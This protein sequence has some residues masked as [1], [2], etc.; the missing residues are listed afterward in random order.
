MSN[1]V[2]TVSRSV[3]ITI[4][5]E[6]VVE[7]CPKSKLY[8]VDW[9]AS[10]AGLVR[11]DCPRWSDGQAERFC[12]QRNFGTPEWMLPDFSKCVSSIL[13]NLYNEVR[14]FFRSYTLGVNLKI[15]T[16][17]TV[18]RSMKSEV[19]LIINFTPNLVLKYSNHENLEIRSRFSQF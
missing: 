9:P 5:D 12:E 10:A 6:G 1:S 16:V 3:Y 11:A 8:D 4:V 19:N 18:F 2:A 14:S 15:N 13:S 17:Y 7:L